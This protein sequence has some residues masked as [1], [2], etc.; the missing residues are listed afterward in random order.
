MTLSPETRL[1]QTGSSPA[2]LSVLDGHA[3]TG[4][5]PDVT[6]PTGHPGGHREGQQTPPSLVVAE[7]R[8]A[9][10]TH[11]PET[12]VT[13]PDSPQRASQ[14]RHWEVELITETLPEKV[15]PGLRLEKGETSMGRGGRLCRRPEVGMGTLPMRMGTLPMGQL[16]EGIQRVFE[17]PDPQHPRKTRASS[18][19][20]FT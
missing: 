4:A 11:T 17:A 19:S 16:P 5:N 13:S 15:V 7:L 10:G 12:T 1:Q 9:Q 8:G 2:L 6:G 3:R 20:I 14:P 18:I